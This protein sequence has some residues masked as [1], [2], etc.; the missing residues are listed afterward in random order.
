MYGE[1]E[2]P[3]GL[4]KTDR[5]VNAYRVGLRVLYQDNTGQLWAKIFNKWWRFPQDIDY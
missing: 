3:K 2:K 4:K 5:K 1:T